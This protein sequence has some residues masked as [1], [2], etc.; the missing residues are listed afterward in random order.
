VI[1]GQSVIDDI[2]AVATDANAVPIE[3]V[4]IETVTIRRVGAAAQTFD[5]NNPNL[6]NV[7]GVRGEIFLNQVESTTN[8]NFRVNEDRAAPT[9]IKAYRSMNLKQWESLGSLY[10]AD[11]AWSGLEIGLGPQNSPTAFYHF[12]RVDYS[13][14]LPSSKA[15]LAN[16]TLV[17]TWGDQSLTFNF[18]ATGEGGTVEYFN[19][20]GLTASVITDSN[21]NS[22][23]WNAEWIIVTENYNPLGILG[24]ADLYENN[25]FSGSGLL[26]KYDDDAS[27]WIEEEEYGNFSFTLH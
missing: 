12:S 1:S 15:G 7:S 3:P 17:F 4:I 6:P 5:S 23:L 22:E 11:Y 24:V 25:V 8:V 13:D 18:D 19:G 10:S 16:T 26:F 27:V 21:N 9:Y 2:N 14:A 20:D